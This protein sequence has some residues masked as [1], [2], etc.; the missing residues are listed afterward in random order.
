MK[1]K[2]P[3][4]RLGSL[5]KSADGKSN[6]NRKNLLVTEEIQGKLEPKSEIVGQAPFP[7]VEKVNLDNETATVGGICEGKTEKAFLIFFKSGKQVWIPKSTIRSEFNPES[8]N[9][10]QFTI[11]TWVLK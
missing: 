5:K 4:T 6:A 2:L 3:T 1:F 8:N 9:M 11:D 10:Q 7:Q